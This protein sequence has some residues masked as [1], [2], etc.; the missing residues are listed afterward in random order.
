M[1]YFTHIHT[2]TYLVKI[3][4]EVTCYFPL[5]ADKGIKAYGY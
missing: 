4:V 1:Y 5:I 2:Q 3:L